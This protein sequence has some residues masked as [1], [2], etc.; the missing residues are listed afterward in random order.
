[1]EIAPEVER[2]M[3]DLGDIYALLS[4]AERKRIIVAVNAFLK[5]AIAAEKDILGAVL[6]AAVKAGAKELN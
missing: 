1:M 4:D 2:G 3:S 6:E 5:V